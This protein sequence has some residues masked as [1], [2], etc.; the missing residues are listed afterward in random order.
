MNEYETQNRGQQTI[1]LAEIF[2]QQS[3]RLLENQAAAA[4]AVMRT[5]ARSFAALGAPDWS[6]LYTQ[7]NER[8]FSEF[9]KTSTDQALSFMRQTN[10]TVRQFQQAFNQL[11]S[12]QTSQLTQQIRTTSAEEIGQGTQ[13]VQQQL[14]EASQHTPQ[15]ARSAAE[16]ALQGSGAEE[17]AR[18]KRPA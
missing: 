8:Q 9:L 12:Q 11:V 13:Q 16:Q 5:Q 6:S 4:R 10:E 2:L 18:N 7:E 17:R 3:A 15:Q 14:R 1:N